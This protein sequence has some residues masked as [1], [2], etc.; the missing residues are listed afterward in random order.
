MPNRRREG[1]GGVGDIETGELE[2]S[3]GGPE[4]REKKR[5]CM[6]L[7]A[8]NVNPTALVVVEHAIRVRNGLNRSR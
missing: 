8:W 5:R 2:V 6:N 1:G 4:R 7:R 3:A